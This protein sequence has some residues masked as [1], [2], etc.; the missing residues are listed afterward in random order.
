MRCV[1]ELRGRYGKGVVCDVLRGADTANVRKFG[2]ATCKTYGS[3]KASVATL[4]DVIEALAAEG[5]LAISEGRFPLV[6]FGARYRAPAEPGFALY[7]KRMSKK[8]ARH[9][10]QGTRQG[11]V[12]RGF[13]PNRFAEDDADV[14]AL[15]ERLRALRKKLAS[16][17]SVPPYV[18]FSDATLRDMARTK[19]QTSEELL[20]IKGVGA[21]K[22][23]R[24]GEAF[25]QVLR[26]KN[27][28]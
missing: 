12:D 4:K 17:Q 6:G 9:A 11:S 18:I 8:S 21:M 1:Q 27:S 14:S 28:V 25:L 20:Q 10:N 5:C 3:S 13:S 26:D 22:L 7:L 23:E 24:Y 15:F 16:E 2:L 19:P